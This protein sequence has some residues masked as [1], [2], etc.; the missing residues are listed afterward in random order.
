MENLRETKKRRS[1]KDGSPDLQVRPD[2]RTTAR[3]V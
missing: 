2:I 3:G 1:E